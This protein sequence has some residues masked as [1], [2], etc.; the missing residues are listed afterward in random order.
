MCRAG[1]HDLD[2]FEMAV[3]AT[4]RTRCGG[5]KKKADR[6]SYVRA[7]E[8][9]REWVLRKRAHS[10]RRKAALRVASE[11][12][13]VAYANPFDWEPDVP[14]MAMGACTEPGT[15]PELFFDEINSG[16][17]EQ[18]KAICQSCLV[19]NYCLEWAVEHDEKFG[20]WGGLTRL[21]RVNTDGRASGSSLVSG[22]RPD[23]AGAR[24]ETII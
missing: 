2:E 8:D 7:I 18:A 12:E 17:I 6:R 4:G 9:G 10:G 19:R 15:D 24:D 11:T 3:P 23:D 5:C 14:F 21:E 16:R 20:I 1:E 13:E 22:R